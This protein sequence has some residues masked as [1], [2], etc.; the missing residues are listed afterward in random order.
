MKLFLSFPIIILTLAFTS[1]FLNAEANSK[2]ITGIV[3]FDV[4]NNK[5]YDDTDIPLKDVAVSTLGHIVTTNSVGMFTIEVNNPDIVFLI[6]PSGYTSPLRENHQPNFYFLNYPEGSPDNLKYK[7]VL[8]TQ[9]PDTLYFPLYRS[10]NENSFR[11]NIIG[12]PQIPN[13]KAIGFFRESI[14]PELLKTNADFN[15][16]LGDIADNNLGIYPLFEESVEP[17]SKPVYTVFGNHDVNYRSPGNEWK[18]E[19]FRS[20]FGPDYYAFNYGKTH[21]IV[22]NSVNYYGWNNKENKR[23][24]YFGG[25]DNKQFE[26]LK[27]DLSLVKDDEQIVLVTHI[28]LIP[29]YFNKED[30]S[31]LKN[32]LKNKKYVTHLSGHLHCFESWKLNEG[33]WPI[34]ESDSSRGFSLAAAC[35]SWWCGPYGEDSIPA[36]T[37]M[38][39]TPNGFFVF[40]FKNINYTYDFLPAG[41]SENFQLR[42]CSPHLSVQ[43]D[44]ITSERIIANVFA[45]DERCRVFYQIDDQPEY[46]MKKFTGLDPFIV[47]TQARRRNMDNWQP[48]IPPSTHLWSAPFPSDIRKGMHVVRVKTVMPTGKKY[49]TASIFKID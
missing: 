39:G 23:G 48:G 8:P 45:G 17:I 42:I 15:L 46:E 4:N 30:L 9:L 24:S 29:K 5:A 47:R 2:K 31:N 44:S 25:I 7:G 16:F 1:T 22:L 13:K 27:K 6:K 32:L 34:F 41:E 40:D 12:D 11:A 14:V 37:C 35:G 28:P 18:A 49:T 26:W 20:H 36:A 38:D 33:N 21:F 19:T 43:K 3:F 10:E